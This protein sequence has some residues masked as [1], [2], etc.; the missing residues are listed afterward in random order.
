MGALTDAQPKCLTPVAGRP[1]FQWAQAA[2]RD[3]GVTRLVVVTGY[4]ADCL[5]GAFE[6]AHN[7]RWAETNMVVSLTCAAEHLR[8]ESCIVSYGDI[9]YSPD[10]VRA[11][12]TSSADLAL[13]Y[14]RQ[15][16]ALWSDRFADPLKDAETFRQENGRLVE[17]G[18]RAATVDQITGQYMGLLKF[19][20]RGWATVEAALATLPPSAVDRLDMTSLLRGLLA[21]GVSIAAVPVDGRWAEVDS[22][23]D[24]AIY[25][26]RI[27]ASEDRSWSHDWRS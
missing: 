26:R 9:V 13:T 6:T 22:A 11:L 19:T 10:H 7:P 2:L 4:R 12:M 1:V 18:G 3:A 23:D 16:L 21:G 14:D 24:A 25:E 27:A 15:W 5:T 8:A 17:I 20:P